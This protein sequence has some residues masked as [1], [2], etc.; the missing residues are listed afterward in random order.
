MSNCF[1][2]L[3]DKEAPKGFMAPGD[4]GKPKG[5]MAPPFLEQSY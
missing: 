1:M 4:E 3:E 2:T 5:F